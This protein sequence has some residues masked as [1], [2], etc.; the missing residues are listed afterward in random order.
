MIMWPR[1]HRKIVKGFIKLCEALSTI[2][3]N[4]MQETM[5]KNLFQTPRYNFKGIISMGLN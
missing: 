1:S 5:L 2:I 3:Y 4:Y